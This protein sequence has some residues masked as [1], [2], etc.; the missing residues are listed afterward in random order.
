MRYL[1]G[2]IGHLEQFPP[3]SNNDETTYEYKDGEDDGVRTLYFSILLFR[4]ILYP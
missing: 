1:G 4:P 3:A 2:G